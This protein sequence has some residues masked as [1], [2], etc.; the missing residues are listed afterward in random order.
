[1]AQKERSSMPEPLLIVDDLVAEYSARGVRRRPFRALSG[2]SIDI[3]PGETVGLVG[4][5]GSGKST[6]VRAAGQE[7]MS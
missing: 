1:M 5:S 2:V 7:A 4:E 3:R 6:L